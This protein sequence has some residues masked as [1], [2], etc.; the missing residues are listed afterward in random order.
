MYPKRGSPSPGLTERECVSLL[1][2]E[3]RFGE[4]AAPRD[5]PPA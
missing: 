1:G 2:Y 3:R 4:A 5:V